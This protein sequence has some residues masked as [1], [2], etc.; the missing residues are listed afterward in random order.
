MFFKK[1]K[2]SNNI[3]SSFE[4]GEKHALMQHKLTD[5][6]GTPEKDQQATYRDPHEL[7]IYRSI[8]KG[9]NPVVSL[10]T[11]DGSIIMF[12]SD[13]SQPHPSTN[14]AYVAEDKTFITNGQK[15][16]P[17]R[18]TV[19]IPSDDS[20]ITHWGPESPVKK[21]KNQY[22][23]QEIVDEI[24]NWEK[25]AHRKGDQYGGY[26]VKEGSTE[27]QIDGKEV[28]EDKFYT[29]LEKLA[30][31]KRKEIEKGESVKQKK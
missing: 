12:D 20:K 22:D 4:I 29:K 5:R 10:S 6:K 31:L 27:F 24:C 30:E 8:N 13:Y 15:V 11:E 14:L 16:D 1:Q 28:S 7:E 19:T 3:N 17:Y 23:Y 18:L 26:H 21:F 9:E 25:H 2:Y